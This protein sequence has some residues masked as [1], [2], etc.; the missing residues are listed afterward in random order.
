[1]PVRAL[2]LVLIAAFAHS[3]W[4]LLAK[5]A[6][7][8]R[9]LI[10]FS[11]LGEAILLLPAALWIL[12]DPRLHIDGR[13]LTA[14]VMTGL[15]HLLYAECLVRGYRSGDLSIV[16]PVAR[17]TGPLLSFA[18]A[19]LVLGERPSVVAALG[20]ICVAAGILVL[21]RADGRGWHAR[22]T[23][24]AWGAVTGVTI[25]SYT[26]VDGYSV[27]RLLLPPLLVEYAGNVFRMLI[28]SIVALRE[29]SGLVAEYRQ[30]WRE[31]LGISILTPAGYVLVLLAMRQA[32][33]SHVAP[34][35][36]VSMLIGAWFG[37]RFLGEGDPLRRIGGA[38]LI[39]LGI[40]ALVL[41]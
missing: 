37:A 12:R 20:T 26:L 36:E 40:A 11:S 4:N 25:A 33:V 34:A 29:R 31:A 28:L 9:H 15:L 19:V 1:V 35:R 27:R 21:A 13:A 24:I 32:S 39:A 3:T 5:R 22:R 41:G 10:W 6:A 14:L 17:G 30:Y 18:G 23:A 38:A 7:T 16:Y 2:V 8:A